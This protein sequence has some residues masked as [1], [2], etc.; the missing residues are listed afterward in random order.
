M[1]SFQDFFFFFLG[2][3]IISENFSISK[4]N[5]I[6]CGSQ[7]Q[8]TTTR[9]YSTSVVLARVMPLCPGRILAK[10]DHPGILISLC[11]VV[12]SKEQWEDALHHGQFWLA[13]QETQNKATKTK[14][15]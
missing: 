5:I 10:T 1:F 6:L 8:G 2:E 7:Q 11:C 4:N 13:T 9:V 15:Q 3:K 14:G 12:F